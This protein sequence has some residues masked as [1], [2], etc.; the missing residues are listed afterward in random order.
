MIAFSSGHPWNRV[1][2]LGLLLFGCKGATGPGAAPEVS[3]VSSVGGLYL[4]TQVDGAPL[5]VP[6]AAPGTADPCPPAITD[7]ELSL[8]P[9]GG[10]RT[11]LFYALSVYSSRACDPDGIPVDASVVVKDAGSWNLDGDHVTFASNQYYRLGTYRGTVHNVSPNAEISFQLQN[12]TY[13]FQRLDPRRDVSS[14]VTAI[15]VDQEGTRV[16]GTLIVF[17]SPNGQVQRAFSGTTGTP[18]IV[19][20]APGTEVIN[21]APPL[22]YTFA[23]GQTNPVKALIKGGEMTRVTVVLAR[24]TGQQH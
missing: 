14:S 19:P 15:I 13:V 9:P 3:E 18:V 24:I 17:H 4:L 6:P 10:E 5:P 16:G 22:G 7:G 11:A 20:A 8:L 23:P 2:F 12:H 1:I 21:V